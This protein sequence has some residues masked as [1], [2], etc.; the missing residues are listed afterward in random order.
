[1][2]DVGSLHCCRCLFSIVHIHL[3]RQVVAVVTG[4]DKVDFMRGLG[5]DAVVDASSCSS[6]LADHEGRSPLHRAIKAVAPKGE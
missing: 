1:M 5:F 6:T 4:Q 2:R 3:W